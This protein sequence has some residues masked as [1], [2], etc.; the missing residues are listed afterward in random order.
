[1]RDTR[2]IDDGGGGG[3]G[4][5]REKELSSLQEPNYDEP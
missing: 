5:G 1:M 2:E 4:D 3:R